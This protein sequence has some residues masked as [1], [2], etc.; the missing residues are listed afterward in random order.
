[1]GDV[2]VLGRVFSLLHQDENLARQQP[3]TKFELHNRSDATDAKTFIHELHSFAVKWNQRTA[4]VYVHGFA[5]S[6]DAAVNRMALLSKQYNFPGVP[7]VLS[8]ASANN[9]MVDF[10][11]G[12][13]CYINDSR[14][15]RKSCEYFQQILGSLVT[16]YGSNN[17]MVL[18]HSMGG[19]LVTD[20]LTSC[21]GSSKV[22]NDAMK[23][24]PLIFAAPDVDQAEFKKESSLMVTRAKNVV[25]Y[26]SQNDV[27]LAI[28]SKFGPGSRR[29][30]QGGEGLL[31]AP[32][33]QTVD[34]SRVESLP[35]GDPN[36]HGYVFDTRQ[37]RQ[38][39]IAV[40]RN[41]PLAQRDCITDSEGHRDPPGAVIGSNPNEY[42]VIQA[43]CQ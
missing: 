9:P 13:V 21:A 5:N 35:G 38:D 29:A 6:F 34:A 2:P 32:P 22:W 31:I 33:V 36:N 42:W 27:A 1:V 43:N 20:M 39:V 26:T 4:F 7:V 14:M 12:Q 24:G 11:T 40:L 23:L 10:T 28:S 30:G 18:A 17:V 19:Q 8:W 37:V 3:N 25:L 41:T 15:I 16:K